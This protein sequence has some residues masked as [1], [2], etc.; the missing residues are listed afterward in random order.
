ME[1]INNIAISCLFLLSPMASALEITA[2]PESNEIHRVLSAYVS[3]NQRWYGTAQGGENKGNTVRFLQAFYSPHG[4]HDRALGTLVQ[5]SYQLD[6]GI[7]QMKL[8][9]NKVLVNN[10]LYISI[11]DKPAWVK[12]EDTAPYASYTCRADNAK[13]CG[14][15]RVSDAAIAAITSDIPV[16]LPKKATAN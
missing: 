12:N 14:F 2:C 10:G 11:V 16:L 1:K 6:A 7:L 15:N 8:R 4:I 3:D 13:N 5:C 9:D